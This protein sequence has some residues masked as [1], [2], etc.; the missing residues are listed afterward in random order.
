M[1]CVNVYSDDSWYETLI[2]TVLWMVF[3]I[4]QLVDDCDTTVNNSYI[5]AMSYCATYFY[6]EYLQILA[7]F[8]GFDKMYLLLLIIFML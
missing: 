8:T 5:V 2:K 6:I 1:F 4:S 3:K 7:I